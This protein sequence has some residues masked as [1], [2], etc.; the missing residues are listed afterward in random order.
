MS[1]AHSRAVVAA[2][3]DDLFGRRDPA[4]VD[5]HIA[6]AY[7]QHSSLAAD[8][9][10]AVRDLVAALGPQFRYDNARIL[11]DGELVAAHGI[12][13]GFGP[14]P[15]VAFDLFRVE[16]GKLAEHWDA[17]T[18][19]LDHTASGHS[20]IDGPTEVTEP[21][22]SD[23]N[24][25]LVTE[26]V[27]RV[28]VGGAY[29]ELPEYF[30]GDA[31]IQHNPAIADGLSGLGQALADFAAQGIAMV[32]HRV[33]R[34]VADGEFVLTQSEGSF[35]GKPYGFYDLFRVQG[36]K[37]A[38]HWDVMAETPSELPHANGLF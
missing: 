3:L 29:E 24:R 17:L 20:Q 36:G 1:A 19:L 35:A 18:P 25:E 21:A 4:A 28:L 26:F 30:D 32:Y 13:H 23:A 27:T 9:R 8:G 33:H 2:A 12:Y 14:E 15:L 5:R 6:P 11:A 10:E 31:Y 7:I 34:V 38:E 37:I 22:S 16:D